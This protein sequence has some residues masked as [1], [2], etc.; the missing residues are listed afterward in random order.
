MHQA[1][2]AEAWR[3]RPDPGGALSL[4]PTLD[5]PSMAALFRRASVS[6]SPSTHDGTPN[7]LLEAMACGCFPIAGDLPSIREWLQDGDNGL[8]I[9]PAD[10]QALAAAVVRAL[11]DDGLRQKAAEANRRLIAERADYERRMPEAVDLYER[12]LRVG[13]SIDAL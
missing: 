6:V 1:A 10:P 8:L 7:T 13:A 3:A 9:D 2:E 12:V 5:A 11:E 4:L